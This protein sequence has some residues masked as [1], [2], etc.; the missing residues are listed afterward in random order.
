[1][2]SRSRAQENPLVHDQ[3]KMLSAMN[4]VRSVC[5]SGWLL[6]GVVAP[7]QVPGA[8]PEEAAPLI[9]SPRVLLERQVVKPDGGVVTFQKIETPV[10]PSAP[11][12]TA[13]PADVARAAVP[14][15]KF[16][17]G[18]HVFE[19]TLSEISWTHEGRR[20]VAWSTVDFRVLGDVGH[21]LHAGCD[22][23]FFVMS[24][25]EKQADFERRQ[26]RLRST[27]P[28]AAA[29][30]TWP[31]FPAAA[32]AAAPAGLKAWYVLTEFDGDESEVAAACAG[33]DALHTHV[34][35]RWAELNA[36][37]AARLQAQQEERAWKETH[38]EPPPSKDVTVQFWALP[39]PEITA[40]QTEE[41]GGSK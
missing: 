33:M 39:A 3:P 1:M 21:V 10:M 29:V 27:L 2:K 20:C 37:L 11:A 19:G 6:A 5:L 32:R 8:S 13:A 15:R 35:A 40:P 23:S 31:A 17:A 36:L 26:A 22:W 12:V 41:K 30:R 16:M 28:D 24:T 25:V 7:A 34:A 9:P 4:P 14:V 18:A 38:P